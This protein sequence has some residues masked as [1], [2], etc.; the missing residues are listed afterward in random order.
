MAR[1]SGTLGLQD[2]PQDIIADVLGEEE[3]EQGSVDVAGDSPVV[4]IG[5]D[6]ASPAQ[7]VGAKEVRRIDIMTSSSG[8]LQLVKLELPTGETVWEFRIWGSRVP[9]KTM[10]EILKKEGLVGFVPEEAKS[11]L[12][13]LE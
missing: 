11:Y 1:R 3:G 13:E 8:M 4:S 2:L 6:D 9:A 12:P 5:A 10:A 7:V